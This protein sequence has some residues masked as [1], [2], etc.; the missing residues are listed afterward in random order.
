MKSDTSTLLLL[1]GGAALVY[2][3]VKNKQPAAQQV[4]NNGADYGQIANDLYSS[5]GGSNGGI[6]N[7]LSEL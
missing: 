6:S 2:L 3:L 5:F 7:L 4:P 1:A